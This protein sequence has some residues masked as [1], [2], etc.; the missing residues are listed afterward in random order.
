[1]TGDRE[2]HKV[3]D[4]AALVMLWAY[5]YYQGNPLVS[6]YLRNLDLS[7]GKGLLDC[8][9]RICP[10]Y[11]EVIV[12]RK[13]FIRNTVRE[14]VEQNPGRVTIVNLGAGFSP[15]ALEL[16]HLLSSRCR[17]IEIDQSA[18]DHKHTLYTHLV[19]DRCGFISCIEGDITDISSLEDA[20]D[21]VQASHLIVV[22]EGLTYYIMRP[23][24]E[25]VLTTLSGIAAKQSIVFE[26]LKP[27]RLIT[28]ERRGIPYRIFS[29]VRDYTAMDRMTTYSK[30]EI[31]AMLPP[32]F[33]CDYYDMSE[34]E[35]MRT[36]LGAFFPTPGSGW[37]SCA[38]ATRRQE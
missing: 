10:W 22:M 30:D 38:V 11:S 36:G 33:A 29:H 25:Q 19:P 32:D 7:S 9:N 20:L 31:Q 28:E 2:R 1:M 13:H 18:M 37:L 4:T 3:S 6:A 27:C 15:L 23:A 8:Y 34:M 21:R 5:E 35:R 17:F 26:H 14:Q 16:V 24:M 12:N